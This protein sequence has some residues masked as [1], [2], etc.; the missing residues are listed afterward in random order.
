MNAKSEPITQGT[1]MAGER[2]PLH[3]RS[4]VVVDANAQRLFAILDD[5]RRLAGHME[6]RSLMM[7]GATMRLE[8]DAQ[9]GQAV[10]SVI[11]AAGRVLGMNLAVEEVV[12]ERVPPLHKSWETRREPR[13][14]VIGS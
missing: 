11:R 6:T 2:C 14:L 9:Q 5:H 12:S 13:L 8:T 1:G 4:E 10:G 3:Y 7:S